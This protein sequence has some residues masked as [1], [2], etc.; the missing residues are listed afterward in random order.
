MSA[1]TFFLAVGYGT[2]IVNGSRAYSRYFCTI[3]VERRRFSLFTQTFGRLCPWMLTF[4]LSLLALIAISSASHAE[5]RIALLITNWKYGDGSSSL[6]SLPRDARSF[7]GELKQDGFDVEM[8]ENLKKQD[9]QNAIDQFKSKIKEGT[10]ALFFFN[11]VGLEYNRQSYIIPA[12]AEIWQ[13]ADI[14]RDGFNLNSLLADLASLGAR[15]KILIID[16]ARR[17]PFERN[18]RDVPSGLAAIDAPPGS[19][20][21]LSATPGKLVPDNAAESNPFVNELLRQIPRPGSAEAAFNRTRLGVYNKS[22]GEQV[23]WVSS[24]LTD[25]FSFKGAEFVVFPEDLPSKASPARQ[26]EAELQTSHSA[27]PALPVPTA[28][29]VAS[30]SSP[31]GFTF[32][33]C[34]GCPELVVVRPGSFKMG[35]SKSPSEMPSHTVKLPNAFA[36]GRFEVTFAEWDRC[37]EAGECRYQPG[38]HGWGRAKIPVGDVSWEDANAYLTWLSH[39]TGQTYR[40]PS[41]A[42]WEFASRGGTSGRFWWGHDQGEGNAN[43]AGCGQQSQGKPLVVGSFKPNS[44]GLYDTA[45]NIAEWVQDCWNENYKGAPSNGSAWL[46]G[47]CS[48]RVLRGGSYNSKAQFVR[49]PARFRYDSDVRYLANGFRALRELR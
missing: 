24:S 7:A 33:D 18:F 41:E 16:A 22:R 44:F 38:D 32:R 49:S 34:D 46:A 11:G 40:L 6:S 20:I 8:K 31:S 48:Q 12:N 25:E 39:K 9:M 28:T 17:N 43:C 10:T 1:S 26:T 13:E 47:N 15:N 21:M 29:E 23:P 4:L 36:I 42:E 30:A 3:S 2:A 19:L 5:T 27:K 45:G 35:S 14:K 37:V